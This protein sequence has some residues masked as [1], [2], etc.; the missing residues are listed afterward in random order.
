MQKKLIHKQI[1]KKLFDFKIVLTI[2]IGFLMLSCMVD[3]N[4]DD[5]LKF[6]QSL[7]VPIGDAELSIEDIL[8][9][10]D[11]VDEYISTNQD[12]IFF[13]YTDS[14]IWSLRD[15]PMM[16]LTN[17]ITRSHTLPFP[18]T[19]PAGNTYNIEIDDVIDLGI[20]DNLDDQRIDSIIAYSAQLSFTLN[21]NQL[22][23]NPSDVKITFTFP[24]GNA[25]QGDL[26]FTNS[27]DNAGIVYQPTA[28][29]VPGNVTLPSFALALRKSGVNLS[30]LPVHV[31]I[32]IKPGS[33][34][35]TLAQSSVS[36][37]MKVTDLAFEYAK[38]LFSPTLTNN[39]QVEEIDLTDFM[40]SLPEGLFRLSEPAINF[41]IRNNLGIKI[42]LNV[43]YFKAYHNDNSPG[44]VYAD[45]GNGRRD[46]QISIAPATKIGE[47]V[48]TSYTINKANG[49]L[50]ALFDNNPIYDMLSY[51]FNTENL[52]KNLAD[53]QDFITPK[54]R[55]KVDFDVRVPLKF[56]AGSYV[57]FSDTI[58][59]IDLDSLL[60]EDYLEKAI[61][62]LKVT[63]GLPIGVQVKPV[64]LAEDY[65]PLDDSLQ[66][67]SVLVSPAPVTSQGAVIKD[68]IE[69][70]NVQIE[71][72][73]DQFTEFKKAKHLYLDV[74]LKG[75]N[76]EKIFFEKSNSIQFKLGIWVKGDY[77]LNLKSNN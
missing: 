16:G 33:S 9:R 2:L 44:E 47:T 41:S 72:E 76:G 26:K 13:S 42:G 64:F 25:S 54:G 61:I 29:G 45:F 27:S 68:N 66:P 46:T 28:F 17:T 74:L 77:T 52:R 20:N 43:D 14:L 8:N 12:S 18:Y 31:N 55:V 7:A 6:D 48:T 51:K 11:S 37:S 15:I 71:I 24:S 67:D 1:M 65:T 63:N 5:E 60:E 38:G 69:A 35:T 22:N 75:D 21:K 3:N 50:D 4:L 36:I 49:K 70:Q 73:K 30:T 39:D 19:I 59:D 40:K 10:I 32:A 34:V 56:N 23:I 57:A 58:K 62:V 53:A